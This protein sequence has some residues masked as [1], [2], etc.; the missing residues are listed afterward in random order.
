MLGIFIDKQCLL[1]KKVF[2]TVTFFEFQF[3]TFKLNQPV[4]K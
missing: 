4:M 2:F 3:Y 1:S